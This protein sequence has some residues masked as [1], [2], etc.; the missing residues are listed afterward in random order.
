MNPHLPLVK[1]VSALASRRLPG[2]NDQLLGRQGN[3]AL[4]LDPCLV[5]DLANFAADR[6]DILG[7]G[8]G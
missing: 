4:Q 5:S 6:V 3:R 1:T 8:A 7:V 2:R